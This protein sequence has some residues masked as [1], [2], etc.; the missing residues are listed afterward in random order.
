[1]NVI[2]ATEMGMCFGVKEALKLAFDRSDA[3]EITIWGE[4]VHN[5]AVLGRLSRHGYHMAP[6]DGRRE[7]PQTPKLLVTAHGISD[8]ERRRLEAA[9]KQL[10]DTT[11]PL[12]VRVHETARRLERTGHHVIVLGRPGHVEVRGIV[13]DLD[14]YTVVAEDDDVRTWPFPKLGVVAQSTFMQANARR[15]LALIERRNPHAAVVGKDTICD[16]T[17]RRVQAL[18]ELLSRVHS[19]V[20]V[21]GRNSNN[22]K[23]LVAACR[24]RSIPAWHVQ[25]AVDLDP[26]WFRA[27]ETVGLT[28]GTS[29]PDETIAEVRNALLA[30]R[31]G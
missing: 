6:E 15:I 11:C 10:I 27:D 30:L 21:G 5:E 25:G 12:V 2:D 23:Q 4:L 1:M 7:L 26:C 28:A 3:H 31:G 13:G 16:P 9:G 14:D 24:K 18:D 17:K 22:T 20:V 8:R 29:T 19:V